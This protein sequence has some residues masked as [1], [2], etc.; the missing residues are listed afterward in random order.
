MDKFDVFINKNSDAHPAQYIVSR[1]K[2][3]TGLLE[4]GVFK[5]ITSKDVPSNTQ[6]FNSHFMDEVKNTSTD[7]AYEK[8]WLVVK[9][10]NNQE[11]DLVLTQSPTI[12]RVN[13]C[14]I[15]CL[16]AM[17]QDN[18]NIKLYLQDIM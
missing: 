5:V 1:Q 15:V 14:L 11:K 4:K 18:N 2:E 12:Q 9:A 17:L 6:I 13:Q 3:I 16:A 10:Y 8:S 7:K